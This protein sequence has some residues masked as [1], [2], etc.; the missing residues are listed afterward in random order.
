M[1]PTLIILKSPL[2]LL[3]DVEERFRNEK[4]GKAEATKSIKGERV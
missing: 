2:H 3:I 1:S 4:I